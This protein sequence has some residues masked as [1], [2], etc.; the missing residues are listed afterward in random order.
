MTDLDGRRV[1]LG[2]SGGIA[3]YKAASLARLLVTAGA[4]VD[5][6]LTRGAANFIGRAT[7][8][9]LTGRPAASEVWEDVTGGAHV[10][11]GRD[12]DV[13][14]VYPATAHTIA[15]LAAGMA[16]DLLTST[17]LAA[18]CP[19]LVAPAMHAEMWTNPATADNVERLVGR[20]VVVLG[21]D[22]GPLMGGDR[23][24]GRVVEPEE[25]LV[26]VA[27]R[28]T[29]RAD[30][31]GTRLLV[32]AGGTQEPID[33]VR[34][35][36]NRSSGRMGF[37]IAEAAHRRGA[38][39]VLV[40][41]PT[42]LATPV[43]VERI[44]VTTALEMRDAVLGHAASVDVVVKA[45]AVADFRPARSAGSKIKRAD[46]VPTVELVANPDIVAEVVAARG[47]APTPFVVAFAAETGDVLTHAAAKLAAKGV[48]LL[49]ANDVARPGTGFGSPDN[50]VVILAPDGR[51]TEVPLAPK[52]LVADAVL[53]AVVERLAI[54][55]RGSARAEG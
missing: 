48:D 23:G 19:V 33:P 3:A 35:L 20:G 9:G 47:T 12:A 25:A 51:T 46:G 24:L 32:T 44:D 5:V 39:V 17:V 8:E 31:V 34:Y 16:D 6:V 37:A 27:A 1:L 26:A 49:V 41:A 36:G 38:E 53:D 15:R 30:L 55:L 43:G 54:G 18:T 11:I 40:A 42:S 4:E 14:I 21:Q 2:V 50:A 29:A 13:I 28:A 22:E 52:A 45:A 10:R 7:F